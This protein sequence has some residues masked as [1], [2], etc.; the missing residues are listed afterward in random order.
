MIP[1]AIPF[2][3]VFAGEMNLSDR[4]DRW[5]FQALPA[6]D[7]AL[8]AW[9]K[10][11]MELRD[12]RS[13]RLA[14]TNEVLLE[15]KRDR[16]HGSAT[17]NWEALGYRQAYLAKV[18]ET[19]VPPSSALAAAFTFAAVAGMA[20]AAFFRLRRWSYTVV[21]PITVASL[22]PRGWWKWLLLACLALPFLAAVNFGVLRALHVNVPTRDPI[23]EAVLKTSGWPMWLAIAGIV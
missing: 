3:I 2:G 8:S 18:T 16:R 9:G 17:P 5:R 7:N 4:Q 23:F 20:I 11:Q 22:P 6:N 1:V 21:R 10:A 12:F 14:G 19:A 15:Y 13:E